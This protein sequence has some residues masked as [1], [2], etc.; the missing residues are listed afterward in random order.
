MLAISAH[1]PSGYVLVFVKPNNYGKHAL[2]SLEQNWRSYFRTHP[3]DI[4]Y[5][6][7]LLAEALEQIAHLGNEEQKRWLPLYEEMREEHMERIRQ[8]IKIA[9]SE[10]PIGYF[11]PSWE[12]AQVLNAWHPEFDPQ[13]APDGYRSVCMF[14]GNQ[15]GKTCVS[16]INKLAWMVPNNPDWVLFGEHE[17]TSAKRR[18]KYRVYRRPDWATWRRTGRMLYPK[19][20]PPMEACEA[21]H[22]VE[23]DKAWSDKVLP[24]YQ[25]WFP[26]NWV[27]RRSDGGTAIYVQDRRLVSRYGHIITGKTF[28]ADLQDW[29]GKADIRFLTIDEGIPPNLLKEGLIRV[30]GG[31]YFMWPYTPVEARNIGQRAACAWKVYKGELKLVGKVKFFLDFNMLDAPEQVCTEEKKE[32]NLSRW[33][34]ADG[35]DKIRREGGFFNSSP[36]VF[37]QYSKERNVLPIDGD[38]VRQAIRGE[39]VPR[40][41]SAFG[42]TRAAHLQ[43]CLLKA[44]IVRGFDEGLANPS[45]GAWGALMRTNEWILFREWEEPGLSV[46]ERAVAM[47][48]RSGNTVECVNPEAMEERRRYRERIEPKGMTCRRTFADSKMFVRDQLSPKDNWVENYSKAGLRLERAGTIGPAGRCDFVSNMLRGDANRTHILHPDQAGCEC[49]VTRDCLK[50][51]ERLENY[52]WSQIASGPRAGEFTGKP[53]TKDDHTVDSF[54]YLL[55]SKLKWVDPSVKAVSPVRYDPMTGSV[56]R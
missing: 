2:A 50:I 21:W 35:E 41:I 22:G 44:N 47:V 13:N 14:C 46:S 42:A 45:A 8:A 4:E 55:G 20:D 49:Y 6:E 51:I 17:D 29:A 39:T 24:E 5:Q 32:D 11:K 16:V 30:G 38:E 43:W 48:E 9:E 7:K 56:L 26:K 23:N 40:W 36:N 28:N 12:Q 18:G 25:K 34:G 37:A 52:L 1:G 27:G 33:T 54:S 53:E 31:G 3:L 10:C 15:I 19:D